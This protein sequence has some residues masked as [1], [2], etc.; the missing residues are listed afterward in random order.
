ML[1]ELP[2]LLILIRVLASV[3]GWYGLHA[4]LGLGGVQVIC[5]V[6]RVIMWWNHTYP[7]SKIGRKVAFA[8]DD[9]SEETVQ[10]GV[11][12]CASASASAAVPSRQIA[13]RDALNVLV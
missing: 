5:T 1:F 9:D 6:V 4:A 10:A 11:P 7:K 2:V 8:C 12:C 13:S 3:G